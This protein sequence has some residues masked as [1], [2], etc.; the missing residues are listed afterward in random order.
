MD[1]AEQNWHTPGAGWSAP[2][3]DLM[4]PLATAWDKI[5][6]VVTALGLAFT[7]VKT[8]VLGKKVQEIHVSVN[9]RL[10]QLIESMRKERN[11]AVEAAT[12]TSHAEGLQQGQAQAAQ[13]AAPP[14]APK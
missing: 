8:W 6:H 7:A 1:A 5:L 11:S 4:E 2:G 10:S 9:S 3:S 14:E 13:A 12:A